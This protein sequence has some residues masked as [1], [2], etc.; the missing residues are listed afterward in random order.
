MPNDL[1]LFHADNSCEQEATEADRKALKI[2][3]GI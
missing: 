2:C 1:I 3:P